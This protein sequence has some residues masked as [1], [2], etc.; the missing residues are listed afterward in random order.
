M[1][2]LRQAR[3]AA[4]MTITDKQL[5]GNQRRSLRKIRARLLEMAD[6]WDGVDQFN[7]SELTGL[8]DKVEEVAVGMVADDGDPG[9]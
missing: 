2:G 7:L 6:Q 9:P 8:A 5:A 1:R 4:P 3:S